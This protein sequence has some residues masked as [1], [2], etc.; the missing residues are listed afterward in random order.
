[1]KSLLVT[2]FILSSVLASAQS[3][4][5]AARAGDT[6]QIEA[7]YSL[8]RDTINSQDV[9]GFTP[10]ILATYRNQL[11]TVKY[12]VRKGADID[13]NSVEGTA[14]HAASYKG[15]LE[16]AEIL[17]KAGADVNVQGGRNSSCLIYAVMS[18]NE[19]LVKL[20]INSGADKNKEDDTGQTALD[21]AERQKSQ[22]LINI[23]K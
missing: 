1:M 4:F 17:V 20:L 18:K 8:N 3:I 16:I 9:N 11:A 12:L 15:N 7:L 19:D 13:Y 10:L 14:L 2:T 5:D 23:L 21:Y 6:S 22:D